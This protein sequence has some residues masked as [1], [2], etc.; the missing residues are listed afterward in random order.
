MNRNERLIRS[1]IRESLLN[2]DVNDV[3]G[4]SLMA[5][6]Q[7]RVYG[8]NTDLYNTFVKPFTDV[9]KTAVGKAKEVTRKVRSGIEVGVKAALQTVIPGLSFNFNKI[10]DKEKEDI[11]KIRSEYQDV[12][13]STKQALSG[14]DAQLLAFMASPQLFMG[15]KLGAASPAIVKN[16]ADVLTGGATTA[17]YDKV[18]EKAQ[19]LGRWSMG[20]DPKKE[21]YEFDDASVLVEILLD[22][23]FIVDEV[24]MIVYGESLNEAEGDKKKTKIMPQTIFKSPKFKDEIE[25]SKIV[26]KMSKQAEAIIQ[27][28]ADQIVAA[29]T[30]DSAEK[31]P[32]Q[33]KEAIQKFLD[34]EEGKK[35][36]DKGKKDY[37]NSVLKAAQK[38]AA[39]EGMK[40][41]DDNLKKTKAPKGSSVA[42]IYGAA[43]QKLAKSAK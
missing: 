7:P 15:G 3:S 36:D 11:E 19:Q 28:T 40:A 32:A 2:E 8:S 37:V 10:F 35:L 34:S 18:K 43:K 42:Q 12:Y 39:K 13:D 31:L 30:F 25:K 41:L 38:S 33:T 24:T 27:N 20:G 29:A 16:T 14:G 21:S 1:Y 22:P 9:G 17:I 4:A 6:E 23:S 26:Q 5:Q